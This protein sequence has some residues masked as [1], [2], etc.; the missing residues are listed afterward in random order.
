MKPCAE[1]DT[2]VAS[3]L[4]STIYAKMPDSVRG[5]SRGRRGGSKRLNGRGGKGKGN[6]TDD[7]DDF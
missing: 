7:D 1:W 5:G 2:L 4:S 6:E 3:E